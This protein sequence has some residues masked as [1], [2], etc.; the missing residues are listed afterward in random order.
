V[1]ATAATA[2][3]QLEAAASLEALSRPAGGGKALCHEQ[4]GDYLGATA[5]VTSMAT[6]DS[7]ARPGKHF[8]VA[9]SQRIG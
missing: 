8:L 1:G 3:G 2:T 6:S 9:T 4:R 7:S 5:T